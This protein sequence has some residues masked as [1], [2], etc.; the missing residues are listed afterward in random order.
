MRRLGHVKLSKLFL[1]DK[2]VKSGSI[3][4][5]FLI[6]RIRELFETSSFI[7]LNIIVMSRGI[8]PESL[9]FETS[10]MRSDFKSVEY[11]GI[12]PDNLLLLKSTV[13]NF[14]NFHNSAGIRP[15][16]LQPLMLRKRR[17]FFADFRTFNK[18]ETLI[19]KCSLL[20]RL[21][22]SSDMELN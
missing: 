4:S 16:K 3:K 12:S 15:P 17:D 10:K 8:C 14:K 9:F 11:D 18:S 2:V 19:L 5:S 13:N 6:S 21:R 20:A 1:R 7:R 22:S